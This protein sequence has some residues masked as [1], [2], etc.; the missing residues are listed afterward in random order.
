M[1]RI[2]T[3]CPEIRVWQDTTCVLI[4]RSSGGN[5]SG[6]GGGVMIVLLLVN[7]FSFDPLDAAGLSLLT[8]VFSTLVGFVQDIRKKLVEKRLSILLRLSAS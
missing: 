1:E 8:L 5:I 6:V 3:K 4:Y 2:N 7:G